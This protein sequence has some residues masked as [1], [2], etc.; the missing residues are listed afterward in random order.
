MWVL[1]FFLLINTSLSTGSV[2]AAFKHAVVQPLIKKKNLDPSDLSNF[3]PIS[4]LRFLSKILEKV[5][6]NQLQLGLHDIPFEHRHPDVR[7]C[8]SHIAEPAMSEV[9][10]LS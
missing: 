3:R 4:K 6:F 1:Q 2:P 8:N 10:E 9:N 7:V 5:V